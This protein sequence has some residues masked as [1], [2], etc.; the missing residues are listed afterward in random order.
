[1]FYWDFAILRRIVSRTQEISYSFRFPCVRLGCCITTWDFESM[2]FNLMD[3]HLRSISKPSSRRESCYA[4]LGSCYSWS[5]SRFMS[6]NFHPIQIVN[7]FTRTVCG[8]LMLSAFAVE[9]M[10]KLGGP[11]CRVWSS[12]DPGWALLSRSGSRPTLSQPLLRHPDQPLRRRGG[13]TASACSDGHISDYF[14][15]IGDVTQRGRYVFS[16][17]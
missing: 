7:L 14:E 15:G 16:V 2:P 12:S 13:P 5:N 17:H 4:F 3:S 9:V 10:K 8:P 11:A 6:I 1:M